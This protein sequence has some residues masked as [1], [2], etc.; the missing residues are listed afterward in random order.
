MQSGA[1]II[2]VDGKVA[3]VTVDSGGTLG[4]TGTVVGTLSNAGTVKPGQSPGTLNV[5][6]SYTQSAGGALNVEI[7]SPINYGKINV[8]GTPGTA[9]LNGTV[10]PT[11]LNG[12]LPSINQS[13]PGIITTSGGLTGTFSQIDNQRITLTLFWQPYYDS[14]SFGLQAVGDYTYPDLNLTPNQFA[15]GSMLNSVSN[16]AS[17]DLVTVLNGINS[18]TTNE[19]VQNSYKQIS[20]EKASALTTLGFASATF[21]VRNLSNRITNLRYEALGATGGARGLSLIYSRLEGMMLAYNGSL[22]GLLTGKKERSPDS[23]WGVFA[24][25]GGVIGSQKTSVN[26]TGFDF[27]I[28]GLTAGA[29]YRVRDNLLVG[30]A[31]GYSHT[32][33]SFHGSGGGMGADT[34]PLNAYAAYIPG[35]LYAYGSLGYALN[36]FD[37]KRQISFD[38]ITRTANSSPAGHQLNFYGETGYDLPVSRVIFTPILSLA[39]SHIWVNGFSE[40]DAGALNLNVSPQ[41]ADSLQTGVGGRVAVPLKV[42][43]A[44]VM[45]QFYASYQHEFSNNSRGLDARLNQGSSTFTWQTDNPKRDFAVL[46]A[47]LTAAITKNLQAQINYNA[48][49]GRG[50]Y[51]AHFVNAGL[52]FEF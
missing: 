20:P 23:R 29:D 10:A 1:Q 35:Q 17:G 2:L 51:T 3:G 12:Y 25:A 8:T 45:P 6:G 48:E 21:Q 50:N 32:S 44:K 14:T 33:A 22:S 34:L 11:L 37:L 9:S 7:E 19:A 36:L 42:G 52:R 38:S 15:V 26:Q 27:G 4:G 43:Q 46:G 5:V 49:V 16:S 39:Y 13:F 41:A 31:T 30:L 47:S 24:D 40:S 18:F 28:I